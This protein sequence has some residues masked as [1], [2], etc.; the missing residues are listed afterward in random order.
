LDDVKASK[1]GADSNQPRLVRNAHVA[2]AKVVIM[3]NPMINN[4]TVRTNRNEAVD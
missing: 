2:T 3:G 1:E 4:T